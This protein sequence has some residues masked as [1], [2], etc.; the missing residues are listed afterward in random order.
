MTDNR[1]LQLLW[2]Y[3]ALTIAAI[4][5]M[6]FP[7]HSEPLA[8][9]YDN[10]PTTWLMSNMWVASGILGSLAVAWLAGLVGLF[11][12]KRWA[13]SLSLYSTLAGFLIAPFMGA[14]LSSGLETSLFDA[15]TTLWG[16]VLALSYFSAVS[17]RFGR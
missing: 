17:D 7:D 10:E 12:F 9:A 15:S 3:V 14:Y 4:V 5:A 2:T 11:R 6:F 16:A 13:R 1:Y 8:I